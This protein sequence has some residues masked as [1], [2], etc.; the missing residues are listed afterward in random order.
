MPATRKT[1]NGTRITGSTRTPEQRE[2][3]RAAAIA[4]RLNPE[5][6]PKSEK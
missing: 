2:A 5:A 1:P 4:K 3:A 6:K